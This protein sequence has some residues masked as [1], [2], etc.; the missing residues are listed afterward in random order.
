MLFLLWSEF[1]RAFWILFPAYAANC[2]P[3]FVR[4]YK[5]KSHPIDFGK[6]YKGNRIFGDGKT[7][8]GLTLGVMAGFLIGLAETVLY[9]S[10]NLYATRYGISLPV[11]NALIAFLIP[12][13]ALMGDL[14]KSFFKRRFGMKRGYNFMFFDQLDFIIGT[15]LFTF[16]LVDYTLIMVAWMFIVTFLIH[17]G[18]SIVGYALKIKREPW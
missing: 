7:W 3:T 11:M 13:G 14:I 2:F 16:L 18:A 1:I 17:R 4:V 8:E 10:L 6:S 12:F 15:I 9:P 5:I